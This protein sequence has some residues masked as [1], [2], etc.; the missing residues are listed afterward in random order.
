MEQ[1][2]YKT[3]IGNEAALK[4]AAPILNAVVGKGNWRLDIHSIDK[5]LTVCSSDLLQEDQAILPLY[6][7]GFVAVN[8]DDYFL[9]Y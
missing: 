9:I 3:N 6:K 2:V 8:L 7:A 4:Q 5:E 1:H